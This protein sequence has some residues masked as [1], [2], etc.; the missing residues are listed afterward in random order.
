MTNM[1]MYKKTN[2]R[3]E[4]GSVKKEKLMRMI[5]RNHNDTNQVQEI[6]EENAY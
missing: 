3:I 1:S 5:R 6:R 4:L 2:M